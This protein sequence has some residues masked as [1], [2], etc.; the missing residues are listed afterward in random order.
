MS[1][2]IRVEVIMNS[3]TYRFTPKIAYKWF[4]DHFPAIVQEQGPLV[5]TTPMWRAILPL[6]W[7]V[8]T[9]VPEVSRIRI[10]RIKRRRKKKVLMRQ[11][12]PQPVQQELHIPGI[13][14]FCS[15]LLTGGRLIY[16]RTIR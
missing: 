14:R 16:T 7:T 13:G 10:L 1:S 15:N 11:V 3:A 9:L 6:A 8:R 2:R 5:D 4:R 12:S